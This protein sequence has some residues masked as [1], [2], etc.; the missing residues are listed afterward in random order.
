MNQTKK[1]FTQSPAERCQTQNF[2]A[3]HQSAQVLIAFSGLQIW[4]FR[5]FLMKFTSS[6]VAERH[7]RVV[8]IAGESY[9]Q[10]NTPSRKT[11]AVDSFRPVSS[12]SFAC[13]PVWLQ[14]RQWSA[15]RPMHTACRS[16]AVSSLGSVRATSVGNCCAYKCVACV[17]R[18]AAFV[19]ARRWK[20]SKMVTINERVDILL[21]SH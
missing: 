9:R 11:A 17:C 16:A 18:F 20:E 14:R 1:G 13:D 19:V 10:T 2:I 21:S 3:K 12:S 15:G 4:A 6:H 7:F 8:T 5:N